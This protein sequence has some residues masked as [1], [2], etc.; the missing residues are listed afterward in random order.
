MFEYVS[1]VWSWRSFWIIIIN[2]GPNDGPYQ[3][4]Q[5]CHFFYSLNI[6]NVF[7]QNQK[8]LKLLNF[9]MKQFFSQFDFLSALSIAN[10]HL[11]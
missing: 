9:P 11:L 7:E 10:F 5:N 3:T 2:P 6:F 4:I 8:K 1:C